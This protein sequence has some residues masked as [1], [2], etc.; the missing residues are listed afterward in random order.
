MAVIAKKA[1]KPAAAKV[2][3]APKSDGWVCQQCGLELVVDDWGDAEITEFFCCAKLMKASARR[4]PV[5]ATKAAIR[6]AI[7]TV[8]K[9]AVKAAVKPAAKTVAKPAIKAAVKPV[10]KAKA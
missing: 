9:P 1:T 4:V 10:A 2:K 5:T 8:A 6:P 3:A 7:K